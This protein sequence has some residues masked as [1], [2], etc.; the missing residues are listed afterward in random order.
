MEHSFTA[1]RRMDLNGLC[2]KT[3][4]ISD[5]EDTITGQVNFRASG[6]RLR[7]LLGIIAVLI[8]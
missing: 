6:L 8:R 3:R 4:K 1:L 5:F 2:V 7:V